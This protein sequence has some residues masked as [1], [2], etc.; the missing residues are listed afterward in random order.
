[1]SCHNRCGKGGIDHRH[2]SKRHSRYTLCTLDR[3]RGAHFDTGQH[4]Q[5]RGGAILLA[6]GRC[7]GTRPRAQSRPGECNTSGDYRR[8]HLRPPRETGENRDVL[9]RSVVHGRFGQMLS[10]PARDELKRQPWR[11]HPD[12]PPRLHR[13]RPRNRRLAR[14][15][16]PVHHVAQRPQD[17]PLPQQDDRCGSESV[18]NRGPRTRCRIC[19]DSRAVLRRGDKGGVRRHIH[20]RA[21]C[22]VGRQ[23]QP[24]IQP[25]ILERILPGTTARRVDIEVRLIGHTDQSVCGQ[26]CALLLQHRRGRVPDGKR[27]AAHR[28]RSRDNRPHNG[29]R[30][31]DGR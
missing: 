4:N 16:K 5:H 12:M 18:Q 28:R 3:G 2:N 14:H 11:L 30:D 9:P 26:G 22:P 21:H 17:N 31:N 13:N 10:E 8:K 25:R 23:P 20:R 15:R 29:S 6:V 1:M 7:R 27:R 24:H 19:E